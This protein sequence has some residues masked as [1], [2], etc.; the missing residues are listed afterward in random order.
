VDVEY[1]ANSYEIDKLTLQAGE[2]TS[3]LEE[4]V[5][6]TK[7]VGGVTHT[8][9]LQDVNEDEDKCGIL[10]D[11]TLAW[12]D[13]GQTKT[14][15]G[16]SLGV[17]D[18]IVVH[19][20][21]KDTDVCEV[22]LGA[23][24]IVLEDG[25]EI[26]INSADIDGSEVTIDGTPANWD[27]LT[28]S[29]EPDEELWL[30]PG[31]EWVDPVFGNFMIKYSG[32]TKVTEEIEVDVAGETAE[33]TFTSVDG[34]EVEI[35]IYCAGDCDS[36]ADAMTLG[37]GDEPDE[38]YYMKNGVCTASTDVA[39]CEGARIIVAANKEVHIVELD[40]IDTSELKIIVKDITYGG[41]SKESSYLANGAEQ[42]LDL[43]SGA[44]TLGLT[45][46]DN[47]SGRTITVTG[48]NA[49]VADA[50]METDLG[51]YVSITSLVT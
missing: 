23:E 43:P 1:D 13:R 22:N 20:A 16:V 7:A 51:A 11:D 28:I 25:Q 15:N 44:G 32:L 40:D 35:P 36:T 33:L 4:G 34:E 17:T 38:T 24:E 8:I 5:E 31:D 37:T 39:D 50:D 6:L 21:G 18:A 29:Y 42:T 49:Y 19:S 41:S 46:I 14:V 12:V 30:A 9:V 26:E 2:T 45:I 10:V 47:S 27:G 48:G 3:W